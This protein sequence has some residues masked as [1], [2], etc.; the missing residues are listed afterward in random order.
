MFFYYIQAFIPLSFG[1][2]SDISYRPFWGGGV[3]TTLTPCSCAKQVCFSWIKISF[4]LV[5]VCSLCLCPLPKCFWAVSLQALTSHIHQQTQISSPVETGCKSY[6]DK[7]K[8]RHF[9]SS[10]DTALKEAKHMVTK[11]SL[12]PL[13]TISVSGRL[14]CNL[15]LKTEGVLWVELDTEAEHQGVH[16]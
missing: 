1:W 9:Q 5:L 4:R 8:K 7:K 6:L 10:P 12:L 15:L 3:K 2:F 14:P 16:P 13:T 11:P